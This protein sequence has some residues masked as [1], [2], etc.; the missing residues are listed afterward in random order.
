M[1]AQ[2]KQAYLAVHNSGEL[3]VSRQDGLRGWNLWEAAGEV[4]VELKPELQ[5]LPARA[6][7]C[8]Q[9][10][11]R[12]GSCL[13]QRSLHA[14]LPQDAA[15]SEL[16]SQICRRRQ[17]ARS[18]EQW[19]RRSEALHCAG[20]PGRSIRPCQ[21]GRQSSSAGRARGSCLLAQGVRGLPAAACMPLASTPS[22][23]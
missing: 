1:A 22:P 18:C 23:P 9:S 14:L 15:V 13:L 10:L 21:G 3:H 5:S 11:L 12:L 7:P 2:L 16:H 19:R 6:C 20:R 17:F 8:L 4:F